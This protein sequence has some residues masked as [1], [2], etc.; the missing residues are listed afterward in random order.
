[1]KEMLQGRASHLHHKPPHTPWQML[2]NSHPF[3]AAGPV[4]F[5]GP[6]QPLTHSVIL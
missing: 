6:F 2:S 1:M 4:T 3:W 5:G